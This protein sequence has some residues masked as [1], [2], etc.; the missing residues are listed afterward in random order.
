MAGA[1]FRYPLNTLLRSGR[2]K[3]VPHKRFSSSRQFALPHSGSIDIEKFK[4]LET[5][6]GNIFKNKYPIYATYEINKLK[7]SYCPETWKTYVGNLKNTDNG[8]LKPLDLELDINTLNDIINKLTR[9]AP[10]ILK[11]YFET[12]LIEL[13]IERVQ[14]ILE[15]LYKNDF[16]LTVPKKEFP[17]IYTKQKESYEFYKELMNT[18][19]ALKIKRVSPSQLQ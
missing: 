8:N 18:V 3:L 16:L 2:Y 7:Q 10:N 9:L 1:L 4:K 11:P 15:D 13:T 14:L 17:N 12:S 6:V 5:Q 19:N